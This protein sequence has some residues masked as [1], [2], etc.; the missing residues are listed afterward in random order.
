MTLLCPEHSTDYLSSM[1][2][3]Q[4]YSFKDLC[5][6]TFTSAHDQW[7]V[8]WGQILKNLSIRLEFVL[9][10]IRK[11]PH[12]RKRKIYHKVLSRAISIPML[13][14]VKYNYELSQKKIQFII[15]LR[16]LHMSCQNSITIMTFLHCIILENNGETHIQ[17]AINNIAPLAESPCWCH[18]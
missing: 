18:L 4:S 13:S 10:D 2:F 11:S 1:L 5:C 9:K 8:N 17:Q 15:F 6:M 3:L 7:K 14:R 16:H 12:R